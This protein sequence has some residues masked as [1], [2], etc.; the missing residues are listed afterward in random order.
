[1]KQFRNVVACPLHPVT[2][3]FLPNRVVGHAT[4]KFI[5]P[6]HPSHVDLRGPSFFLFVSIFAGWVRAI[7][8]NALG[9]PPNMPPS[10]LENKTLIKGVIHHHCPLIAFMTPLI[11]PQIPHDL[12]ALIALYMKTISVLKADRALALLASWAISKTPKVFWCM[13]LGI[14]VVQL[15]M[16]DMNRI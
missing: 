1:M 8:G 14:R 6:F 13:K 7:H 11:T 15:L 10:T 5:Q 12:I 16:W 4:C 3:H 2:V 9:T